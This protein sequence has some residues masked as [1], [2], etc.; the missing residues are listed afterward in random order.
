M[1]KTLLKVQLASLKNQLTGGSRRKQK[2]TKGRV[3]LMVVL[4]LY[5][6]GT[7]GVLFFENFSVLAGA[8][9]GVGLDWLYF[10]MAALMCFGLMFVGSVFSAKAQL[11]EARDNDLLL[12]MPIRPRDILISRM[13][14]LWLIAMFFGLLVS[15]PAWLAWQMAAGF[16]GAQLAVYLIQFVLLLPLL[17]L[18]VSALFGWLLHLAT[19]RVGNKSLVTVVLS[20]IFLGAYMYVVSQMNL[21]VQKLAQNADGAA[22]KF[23]AVAPLYAMG[24]SVA[25]GRLPLLLILAACI[26]ALFVVTCVLLS[27]TFIRTATDRRSGPKKKYVE[28]TVAAV[29]PRRALLRREWRHFL[30]NPSY[31]LNCGLGSIMLVIAAVFLAVESRQIRTL[32]ADPDF[33]MLLPWLFILGLCFCSGMTLVTAPS[34]SLEGKSLWI[35]R[36]LPV[37]SRDVLKAKLRLHELIVLPPT[38]LTAIVAVLIVKPGWQLALCLLLLPLLFSLFTALLGLA[39]NLRHPN[40]DWINETQ[41]VKSGTSILLTML[42]SW[43]VMVLPILGMVFLS[44]A[45]SMETIGLVFASLLAIAC[46]LLYRWLL[47]GGVRRFET[48]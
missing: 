30:A 42:I 37:E 44:S 28:R 5:A 7:F 1:L 41:A 16:T 18:T 25:Q 6:F 8:F 2:P 29:S 35:V 40:F 22:Q 15:V 38:A 13:L 27:R 34:I 45:V 36:S 20:L 4:L 17:S 21:L 9:H 32:L 47:R 12:S 43:G 23:S 10:S 14:L 24:V 33:G 11:Y 39:E 3:V 26:L 46:L 31:I 19:A 48:L